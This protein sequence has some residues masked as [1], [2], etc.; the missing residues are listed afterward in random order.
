[1]EDDCKTVIK[2]GLM[3]EMST[4]AFKTFDEWWEKAERQSKVIFNILI[5]LWLI[6]IFKFAQSTSVTNEEFKS[7]KPAPTLDNTL[8][9]K[10]EGLETLTENGFGLGIQATIPKVSYYKYIVLF[11]INE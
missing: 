10:T 11:V 3:E 7:E 2:S 1:M 4:V 5:V 8:K 6:I 9:G